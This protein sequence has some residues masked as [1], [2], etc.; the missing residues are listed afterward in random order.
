M[1]IEH[2]AA[3]AL[4]APDAML[5]SPASFIT[6]CFAGGLAGIYGVVSRIGIFTAAILFRRH[7]WSFHCVLHSF[8]K[9][10]LSPEADNDLKASVVLGG[11]SCFCQLAFNLTG[12]ACHGLLLI[13]SQPKII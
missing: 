7:L 11:G 1:H 8:I 3:A 13:V 6:R 12:S 4:P 10:N 9:S 5:S 2:P